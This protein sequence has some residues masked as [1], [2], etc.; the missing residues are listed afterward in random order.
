MSM[1]MGDN[2]QQDSLRIARRQGGVHLLFCHLRD[3]GKRIWR[4]SLLYSELW[5]SLS[6][7]RLCLMGIVGTAKG[8]DTQYF[9]P[10]S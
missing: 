3:R 5:V 4:S 10:I 7:M 2:F 6:Y 9:S 8:Q 1:D